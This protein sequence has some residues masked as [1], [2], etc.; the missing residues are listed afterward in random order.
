[1][2]INHYFTLGNYELGNQQK[3]SKNKDEAHKYGVKIVVDVV[4]NHLADVPRR[5]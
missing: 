5:C 3:N 1:M 2:H 4:A